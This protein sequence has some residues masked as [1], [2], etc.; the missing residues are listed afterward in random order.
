[1]STVKPNSKIKE[2]GHQWETRH[3]W[4]TIKRNKIDD[5]VD[6]TDDDDFDDEDDDVD[7]D[8][9]DHVEES[10]PHE[11][12]VIEEAVSPRS[13]VGTPNQARIVWS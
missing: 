7:D 12:G 13:T 3:L 10:G 4:R 8:D 6:D 1:M 11:V 9:D 5:D 2:G